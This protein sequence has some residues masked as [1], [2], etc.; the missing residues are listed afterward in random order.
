MY[1]VRPMISVHQACEWGGV[2][3]R[4]HKARD[5][6]MGISPH[7]KAGEETKTYEAKATGSASRCS[8]E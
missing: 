5:I 7:R 3:L 8:P 1:V 6:G 2:S 4:V